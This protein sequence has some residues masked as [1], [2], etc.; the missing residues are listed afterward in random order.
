MSVIPLLAA[1]RHDLPRPA[2]P[3]D[4]L[5]RLPDRPCPRRRR[6]ALP[7]RG[8]RAPGRAA[9]RRA[10]PHPARVH[11]RREQHDRQR[12][13]HPRL[14][15]RLPRARRPAVRGR[16]SRLRRDRR[17]QPGRVVPLR[18]QGQQRGPP[19]R[20]DL[21]QPRARRR[22]L[23]VLLGAAGVHRLPERRQADAEGRRAALSLL[24]PIARRI[25]RRRDQ[26]VRGER[27][28]RRRAAA[29]ALRPH[30]QGARQAGRARRADAQPAPASRSSRSRSA[31]IAASARWAAS[32]STAAS[33]SRWPPIPSCPRPRSASA[34]S[35]PP[36]T[37]TRRSTCCSTA[38]EELAE[39]GELRRVGEEAPESVEAAA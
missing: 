25:A 27:L 31:T 17:A 9:A 14:R 13:G 15:R 36:P 3:Q 11:G 5:R 29:G 34:C 35:S 8:P 26:G 39:R 7:L 19:L 22:L 10:R 1:S 28:A 33:T 16:R 12:A 4:D 23:Q 20:R 21:R 37:P 38:L 18:P 32:C 2:R 24:G 30:H 6:E